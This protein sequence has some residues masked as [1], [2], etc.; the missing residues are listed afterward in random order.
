MHTTSCAGRILSHT[1]VL[2]RQFGTGSWRTPPDSF[3]TPFLPPCQHRERHAE[4]SCMP[5]KNTSS[6][7]ELAC[8]PTRAS[9]AD[10]CTRKARGC[11][12][13]HNLTARVFV[14]L[15]CCS[16]YAGPVCIYMLLFDHRCFSHRP[17]RMTRKQKYSFPLR[18]NHANGPDRR[19]T[20]VLMVTKSQYPD[21]RRKTQSIVQRN[22]TATA[23]HAD[24]V[25]IPPKAAA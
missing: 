4:Q 13:K 18:R 12:E 1:V 21:K 10:A 3:K 5:M 7:A 20:A 8:S 24:S 15:R 9:R 6:K 17:H 16:I 14:L 11:A 23:L 22:Q 19:F 2:Y 25:G